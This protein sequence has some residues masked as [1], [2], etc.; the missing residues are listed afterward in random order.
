MEES[1]IALLM[2]HAVKMLENDEI[3]HTNH[4]EEAKKISA[5]LPE[6]LEFD[7]VSTDEHYQYISTICS[8]YKPGEE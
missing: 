8:I 5:I 3:E 6:G 1:D 4:S 2:F 7:A